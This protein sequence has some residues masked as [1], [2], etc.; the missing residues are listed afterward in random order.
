MAVKFKKYRS[1]G[2][3]LDRFKVLFDCVY[4]EPMLMQ[5]KH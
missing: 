2:L 3:P 1:T 4:V 5:A